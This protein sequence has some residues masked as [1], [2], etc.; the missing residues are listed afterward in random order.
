MPAERARA[1]ERRLSRL[2]G[3]CGCEEGGIGLLVGVAGYLLYL[4]LRPGGWSP[5]DNFDL[6]A[7]LAVLFIGTSAGKLLGLRIAQRELQNAA[8]EIRAQWAARQ[9]KD[10]PGLTEAAQNFRHGIRASTCCGDSRRNVSGN[11]GS[12]G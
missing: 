2:Q 7:G 1:W 8:W 4:T 3:A 12:G 5:L 11:A 9:S 10:G 6:W